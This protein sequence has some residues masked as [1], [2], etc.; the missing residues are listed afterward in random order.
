MD[1]T[2][3]QLEERL[4]ALFPASDA[5]SWD[6][7]GLLVGDPAV[8]VTGVLV[9]LDPTVQAVQRAVSQGCNV[10][11]T[12][13]PVFLDPPDHFAPLSPAYGESGSVVYEAIANGVALVNFHTALDVSLRAAHVLPDALGLTLT[14][15]LEV[16]R[17]DPDRGYGQVCSCP[18]GVTLERLASIAQERLGGRPRV[19]GALHAS[20]KTVVTATGAAG[21]LAEACLAAGI[22]CLVCGEVK[23][24][25][26]LDAAHRG[27]SIIELG[28][29]ISEQQL[30]AVLLESL[31]L[32]GLE[33]H[34]AHLM[35]EVAN[36]R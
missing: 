14:G 31:L 34:Q 15:I 21:G 16:V 5:E 3:G 18:Q 25:A 4:L 6:R 9:C 1:I 28:H 23:Y 20:P 12:H 35:N 32:I 22:D 33:P 7:T 11:L 17:T 13:H 36:W 30:C 8:E 27:L 19:W 29:D 26:A 2:V 24:H 10:V